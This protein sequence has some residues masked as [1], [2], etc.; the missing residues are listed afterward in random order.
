M[1]LRIKLIWPTLVSIAAIFVISKVYIYH[2]VHL[3]SKVKLAEDTRLLINIASH[4]IKDALSVNDKQKVESILSELLQ[5]SA[6]AAVQLKDSDKRTITFLSKDGVTL[7]QLNEMKSSGSNAESEY[8]YIEVAITHYGSIVALIEVK[9]TNPSV[10]M[11]VTDGII[12]TLILLLVG[13]LLRALTDRSAFKPL[14]DLK[15]AVDDF[16]SGH[17]FKV[18]RG[19][20]LR[21]EIDE[22]L[23]S[24]ESMVTKHR[25]RDKQ[26]QHNLESLK[27][28]N[29]FLQ[30]VIES[31]QYA[32]ITVDRKGM[33]I[34]CNS[35]TY[36]IFN[37]NNHHLLQT[38][39]RDL[40]KTK[41]GRELAQFLEKSSQCNEMTLTDVDSSR[42]FNV[43]SRYLSDQSCM[44]FEVR[45]V[46]ELEASLSREHI[47]GRVFESSQDGL[48][49][50]DHKGVITMI[51]P[52][53]SKLMGVAND[54]L[55]G[56][57]LINNIRH[58]KLRRMVPHIVQSLTNYGIWQG[59]ILEE[60][61]L[62]KLIPMF[63]KVNCI[64]KCERNSLYDSV[65]VLT[66]LS[67]A[68]EMERLEYLA[69]HDP[70]TGLANRAKFNAELE[71]LV[72]RSAYV[73]D[74]FAVLYL[75]LDGFKA[76]NDTYGHDAGDEVLRIVSKRLV[77]ATR[78]G[79][80]IAR[81]SGDEFAM[82]VNPANQT[83]VTRI[84][85]QLLTAICNP[86][87]YGQNDLQVGVSIGVKLVSINERDA[88]R[89]L[90]SA[91]TAMY[92]AKKSGKGRAI[93]M[94]YEL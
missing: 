42:Q 54:Q 92:Q 48:I 46:T 86:I 6:I 50:L 16:G 9:L 45:D 82:L 11:L 73:R 10:L 81:L 30:D 40:I 31:L 64:V 53:A 69:H 21:D 78:H 20:D 5:Q 57:P 25:Q 38:H 8:E 28:E 33:I 1:S 83:I 72:Q 84:A 71:D 58:L 34:H 26:R 77:S 75:D 47:A 19:H 93:L 62:G 32:L 39:V 94:G 35:A 18:E 55:V 2:A 27:Q 59:E 66:D 51:N 88:A 29:C 68:K 22:L 24:F 91:D 79:D 15:L 37:R 85:E 13:V 4:S 87:Q 60:N 76:I 90:K 17:Q 65:I 67:D 56:K 70:L 12:G 52:A 49:V 61:R 36:Q 14:L 89:V 43:S 44:L 3:S 63:A 74:E 23:C 41:T 80:L 7:T